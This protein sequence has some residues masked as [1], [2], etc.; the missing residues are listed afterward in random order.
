MSENR[1]YVHN[2]ENDVNARR[3]LL[4]AM[5]ENH[6]LSDEEYKK[7]VKKLEEKK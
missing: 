1:E 4:E 3:K 2:D 6:F 7:D 5:H